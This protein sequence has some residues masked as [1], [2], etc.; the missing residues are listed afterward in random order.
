MAKR[1]KRRARGNSVPPAAAGAV[2]RA[3]ATPGISELFTEA[4][5]HHQAGRLGEAWPL[6]RQVLTL[7]SNHIE[8]LYHLGVLARQ[9]GRNDLAA[10]LIGK[11]IALK[12]DYA[13]AHY[14]LGIVLRDQG[15]LEAAA[16]S[17]RRAIAV[18]PGY[19]EAHYNLGASS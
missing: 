7:N 9:I 18:K 2:V 14:N 17:W 1:K 15:R 3:E 19:A 6:Y 12:P 13:E 5:R 16:A 4:V 8:C 10:D 11:A